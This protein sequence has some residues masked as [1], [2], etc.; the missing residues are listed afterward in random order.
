MRAAAS[1]TG[2]TITATTASTTTAGTSSTNASYI[3]NPMG[4]VPTSP[5]GGAAAEQQ[6]AG[7]VDADRRNRGLSIGGADD[8]WNTD[9]MDEQLFEFLMSE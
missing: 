2:L 9:V 4:S 6:G 1:A 5:S 3:P 7:E 8:F